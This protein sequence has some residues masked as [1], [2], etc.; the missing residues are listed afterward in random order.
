V[1]STTANYI[2]H[3]PITFT[4]KVWEGGSRYDSPTTYYRDTLTW[5]EVNG[6]IA[7]GPPDTFHNFPGWAVPEPSTFTLAGLGAAALL[8]SRRGKL[9]QRP[10]ATVENGS[11]ARP[12]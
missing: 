1:V 7:G 2:S 12:G 5:T 3:Q 11:V 9:T 10:R 6:F 4:I 8:V